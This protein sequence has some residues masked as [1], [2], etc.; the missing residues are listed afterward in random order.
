MSGGKIL[1]A[2]DDPEILSSIQELL[3]ASGYTVLC[4][5]DG[6][7]ALRLAA[8][9]SPD[10]L[11]LDVMMGHVSGYD[12]VQKLKKQPSTK[13]LP[14]IVMSGKNSMKDFFDSWGIAAFL[15]KPFNLDELISVVE[16]T[17]EKYGRSPEPAAGTQIAADHSPVSRPPSAA[18]A[19]AKVVYVVAFDRV[20]AR[21]AAIMAQA[22]GCTVFTLERDQ[23]LVDGYLGRLALSIA[24]ERGYAARTLQ[25]YR[26]VAAPEGPAPDVVLCQ[27]CKKLL[28]M[29][30]IVVWRTLHRRQDTPSIRFVVFCPTEL[31]EEASAVLMNPEIITHGT[32]AELMD[33]IKQAL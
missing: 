9:A 4:A 1:V 8:E 23:P 5:P 28:Q 18:V 33:G 20:F 17:L 24:D 14:V 16:K 27:Y 31:K 13:D 22:R 3:E 26:Q 19:G 25:K 11:L 10:L 32:V 12:V 30:S 29:E 7:T 21:Q 15:G 2:D 6:V